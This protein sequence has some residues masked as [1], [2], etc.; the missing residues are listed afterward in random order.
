MENRQ[1]IREKDTGIKLRF[2]FMSLWLL[3]VLIF[4]LT[5]DIPISFAKDAH[6]IGIMP[7]LEKNWL[8]FSS[9]LLAILGWIVASGEKRRWAGV[10]NPPYKIKS[11]KNQN[12]ELI[13]KIKN[14]FTE[15]NNVNEIL[16]FIHHFHKMFIKFRYC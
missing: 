10:S 16:F 3:F 12:Y 13:I 5:I 9:L 2:Y 7:L 14:F 11:I 1:K 4:L 6:F 15:L 8:A